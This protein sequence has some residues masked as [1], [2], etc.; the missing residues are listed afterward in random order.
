MYCPMNLA[1]LVGTSHYM[2][3]SRGSNSGHSTYLRWNFKSIGY[4]PKKN[5]V[6]VFEEQPQ[7]K[8]YIYE[9]T[10]IKVIGQI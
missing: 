6:H 5:I 1:Q 4:L 8:K 10:Q 3:R 9:K 2:C 7:F